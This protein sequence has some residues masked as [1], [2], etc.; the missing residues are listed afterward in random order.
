MDPIEP[1]E[2][3]LLTGKERFGSGATVGE[4]WRWALGDVRMNSA[5]GYLVEFL[6]A[7][8]LGDP[9]PMRIEW[10]PYDV[11]GA[12]GTLVE[13]KTTGYLQSWTQKRLSTPQWTFPS[14]FA[15]EV[16][17]PELVATVPVDPESRVHVWVF[18]LQTCKI[19]AAYNPLDL[20]QWE[21]RVV[22]HRQL[23]R[24]R[25]KS[26][27]ISFLDGLGVQPVP[28]EQLP[29]EVQRARAENDQLGSASV[30]HA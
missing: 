23:I 4:F 21:F 15:S 24:A 7:K 14:V 27:R 16:W 6:V 30:R 22:P 29:L 12:D 20:D 13:I 8:A 17:S 3:E 5:R 10:G 2:L 18:A 26:G 28:Y 11:R 25:Q 1:R 9:S 19:P